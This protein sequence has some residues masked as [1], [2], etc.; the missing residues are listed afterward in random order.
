MAS[1]LFIAK[2]F[3][4]LIEAL[5][6]PIF[7]KYSWW[8]IWIFWTLISI[9]VWAYCF[10]GFQPS[11]PSATHGLKSWQIVILCDFLVYLFFISCLIIYA[12]KVWREKVRRRK[13]SERPIESLHTN[14]KETLSNV[15]I[16]KTVH[17]DD[18]VYEPSTDSLITLENIEY[19]WNNNSRMLGAFAWNTEEQQ[20]LSQ[21]ISD[22]GT[23]R[24]ADGW[25]FS[26][27]YDNVL[28]GL[29]FKHLIRVK[30][31]KAKP[32]TTEQLKSIILK[33]E[34]LSEED[35]AAMET[36]FEWTQY[37]YETMARTFYETATWNPDSYTEEL[38]R[39]VKWRIS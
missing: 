13:L 10:Y 11:N 12:L 22:Y 2:F 25:A 23:T 6:F 19:W 21:E 29:V 24:G 20:L 16:E 4:S 15:H 1:E 28:R 35:I 9:S 39:L 17:K 26:T 33:D 32:P 8:K 27:N 36:A 5:I 18:E 7:K 34:E 30:N 37:E 38:R 31:K 14:K 3:A